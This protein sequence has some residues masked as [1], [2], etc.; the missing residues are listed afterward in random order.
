MATDAAARYD[1]LLYRAA[2]RLC[3]GEFH[4]D[5]GDEMACDFDDARDE[6]ASAGRRALWTLRVLIGLDLAR[7]LVVQ[8]LRTGVPAIGCVAL[9]CSSAMAAGLATVA[10]RLTVR[11]PTDRVDS[12]I[13]GVVLL[14]AVAVMVIVMTIVFNLWVHRPRRAARR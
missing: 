8:W 13:V 6:A 1:A 14:A 12:E 9:A 11:I 10:R 3:P 7:T 2:L 5:H 4:R